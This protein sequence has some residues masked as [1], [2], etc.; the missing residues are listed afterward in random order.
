MKLFSKERR[1]ERSKYYHTKTWRNIRASQLRK[2][3]LCEL[4]RKNYHKIT[5]ATVCDH[6]KPWETLEEF[7]KGP[8]QS[9]CK[10]CHDLKSRDVD[11]PMLLREQKTKITGEDV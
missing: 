10:P 11:V 8:F 6:I 2:S 5:V 9:L 7:K 4:C 1:E 3:A